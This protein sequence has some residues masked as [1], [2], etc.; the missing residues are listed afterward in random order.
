MTTIPW[1]AFM[2]TI[3][4]TAAATPPGTTFHRDV[5][6]ILQKRC[7]GC[8][9]SGEAAPMPLLTY[10]EARPWAR[11][12][13]EAVR[14]R[15]MPPWF[16]DPAVGRFG[17]DRSLSPEEIATI[18]RWVDSG[19]PEGA[20]KDAPPPLKFV[21]GWNIG[22]PDVVFEMP[23]SYEVPARG[24]VDYTYIIIP[25]NFAEDR[26][27]QKVEVRPGARAVVHHVAVWLRTRESKWFRE[28]PVGKLFVPK[29]RAGATRRDSEGD[30]LREGSML[31]DWLGGYS[32]G[33][34]PRTLPPGS[35][36]LLP[37]G[38]DIVV[39]LHYTTNGKKAVD[40]SRIGIVFAREAPKK[41]VVTLDARNENLVIPPGAPAHMEHAEVTLLAE[42]E[43]MALVPHM[44]VR[45]K[46]FEMRAVYPT[47]EKEVLLRV[48]RYDF[49]WQLGY[50]LAKPKLLPKG[51][52]IEATG[53]FDNSAN[54]R[55]NPDS[56]R[57]VRWGDQSWE[58]MLVGF[59]I[60]AIDTR[61]DPRMLLGDPL[62]VSHSRGDE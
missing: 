22:E 5:V 17:N 19:A 10:A 12:I 52:R 44:H 49:N 54:N 55:L 35:A 36:M 18:S 46:S 50:G 31:D 51:T 13:K 26:W 58:E 37:K 4:A 57:E 6:P 41:R 14:S 47:G 3:A 16:A 48:P 7:Q 29:P 60:V 28:Y 39:S 33:N 43:L 42:A 45:G 21:D 61:E 24:T 23:E 32:P 34:I 25:T 11:A 59:F 20:P 9:R 53:V 2:G 30:R 56:T 15:R 62:R 27:V 40:R 38:A 1:I 8:H